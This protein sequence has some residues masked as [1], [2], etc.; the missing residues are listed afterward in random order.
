MTADVPGRDATG[1]P[2]SN[3]PDEAPPFGTELMGV[4][5][6]A[7]VNGSGNPLPPN[8]GQPSD[9]GTPPVAGDG[10]CSNCLSNECPDAIEACNA[11][12]GCAAISA[13]ARSTGCLEDACY[14]GTVNTLLCGTTGQGDGPC[15]DVILAAPESHEPTPAAPNGGPASEAAQIVGRCRRASVGCRDLCAGPGD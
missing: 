2:E 13:C 12:P 1:T 14:C 9:A 3:G 11:T 6:A 4:A 8:G 10:A 15:R 7:T 5:G